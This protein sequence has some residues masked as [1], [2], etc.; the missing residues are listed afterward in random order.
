MFCG[1]LK[2]ISTWLYT[3][4]RNL[5]KPD[6]QSRCLGG[7]AL[8]CDMQLSDLQSRVLTSLVGVP[9]LGLLF[10]LGGAGLTLLCTLLSLLAF[11][12]MCN[13][14]K[15]KG[16]GHSRGWVMPYVVVL[17][18]AAG[19]STLDFH[20]LF[21]TLTAIWMLALLARELFSSRSEVLAGIGGAMTAA[22]IGTL[23]FAA[24]T[25][26]NREL[27]AADAPAGPLMIMLLIST[28]A[29]DTFAYFGGRF[30]GRH[31]LFERVSPKKTIEGFVAGLLGAMFAGSLA[32]RF[33]S[34][35][36]VPAGLLLGLIMGLLGPMGDLLESRLK[37]DA[38]VKDSANLLPGHG[39]VLDRFDSWI[40]AVPVLHLLSRLDVL[41]APF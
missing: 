13:L 26:M 41:P 17:P 9:I 38:G 34:P 4:G 18:L 33:F 31:K 40:F 30:F 5:C 20:A 8:P 37:R 22:L 16:I 24:L 32:A 29:T 39:G 19:F 11:L 1:R 35:E 12:E 25:A 27:V 15:E 28:W 23:P 21:G 3:K 36:L 2:E 10:W 7:K 14:L 6:F